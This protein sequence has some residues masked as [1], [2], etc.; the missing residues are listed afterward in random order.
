MPV[1]GFVCE[2]MSASTCASLHVRGYENV[3]AQAYECA[4]VT[5]VGVQVCDKCARM[6]VQMH[7]KRAL[8]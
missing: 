2:G 6:S 4:C 1:Q 8:V 3:S 5:Y 7:S